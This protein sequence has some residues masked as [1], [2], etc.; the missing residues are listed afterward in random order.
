[1]MTHTHCWQ[2]QRSPSIAAWTRTSAP[3]RE[4]SAKPQRSE[5]GAGSQYVPRQSRRDGSCSRWCRFTH[6]TG[7]GRTSL[8]SKSKR[9]RPQVVRRRSGAG[10][11]YLLGR[12]SPTS[13]AATRAPGLHTL[14]HTPRSAS[15]EKITATDTVQTQ[16]TTERSTGWLCFFR[17]SRRETRL[18]KNLIQRGGTNGH[19]S[20]AEPGHCLS[21]EQTAKPQSS[22]RA[23]RGTAN[24][25]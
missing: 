14:R 1:M 23:R 4:Q 24:C 2:S 5:A 19:W 13:G 9:A 3:A 17:S 16:Q 12:E 10:G 18:T 20:L 8:S 15:S 21:P 7:A 6:R 25:G 11:I 22:H